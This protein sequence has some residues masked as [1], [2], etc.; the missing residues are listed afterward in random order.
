V[1][2]QWQSNTFEPTGNFV[3][4]IS[5]VS[6][7]GSANFVFPSAMPFMMLGNDGTAFAANSTGITAL[8]VNSGSVLWTYSQPLLNLLAA[9]PDGGVILNQ[10]GAGLVT[11]DPSGTRI[12]SSGTDVA[13]ALPFSL[14]GWGGIVMQNFQDF[15]GPTGDFAQNE[16]QFQS[17]SPQGNRH[18]D[19]PHPVNYRVLNATSEKNGAIPHV[20]EIDAWDSSSGRPV[21]LIGCRIR[22]HVTYKGPGSNASCSGNPQMTCFFPI[23]P[24]WPRSSTR[25]AGFPNPTDVAINAL[26]AIPQ[27]ILDTIPG[28]KT[29]QLGAPD[30][31]ATD[32]VSFVQPYSKSSFVGTQVHQWQC[33][34]ME[35]T[36]W[37]D[38]SKP[39]TITR[40]L[41]QNSSG[42][43]ITV[44]TKKGPGVNVSDTSLLL[45]QP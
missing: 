19:R 13:S 29:P 3:Y 37:V 28:A 44:V 24:P 25:G 34:P 5:N 39:F 42:Q 36:Q 43:W 40:E 17:E 18:R 14:T 23:S 35:A 26:S 33:D 31:H 20:D 22:E 10:P 41:K 2:V 38:L 9:T 30:K 1:L 21:D 45:V 32:N 27:E 7:G 15:S 4:R 8:N 11:L 6:A 16:Y 12:A